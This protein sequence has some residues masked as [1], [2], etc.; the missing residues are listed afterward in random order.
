V[1]KTRLA[2][3]VVREVAGQFPDGVRFVELGGVTD[4]SRVPA[5]V[6]AALGVQQ[7][8]GKTPGEM[9]AAALAPQR[10]LLVLDNC[11]QVAAAVAELCAELLGAADDL[12]ILATSREQLWVDGEVRYRLSPLSVPGSSQ[13]AEI[14]RSEAVAL[15][16]ERARRAAP[17]FA[18]TPE[19]APMAARVVARLDGMPLAIEL[20]AARIEALGLAGLADR[21]DDALPLLESR[22]SRATARHRSLAAVADWSYRLLP[23]AE[24]RVFRRLTVFPGPFTLDAAEAVAGPGA[25]A[26]VLQ[27]V[28][29]SLVTPPQPGPDGRMRYSLLQTLRAYGLTL[30]A[31]AG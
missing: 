12:H 30:L 5:E 15:L 17:Q 16:T 14:A 8:P 3:E 4:L 11:E 29:C 21:I 27:L 26:T 23:W 9:L 24:Q 28:D 18:L 20:A 31:D 19:F 10:L 2:V 25:R 13:L 6:A 22:N 7:A 1:G